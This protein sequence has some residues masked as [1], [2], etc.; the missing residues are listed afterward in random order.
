MR[1]KIKTPGLRPRPRLRDTRASSSL[2]HYSFSDMMSPLPLFVYFDTADMHCPV[3]A[4]CKPPDNKTTGPQSDPR[5]DWDMIRIHKSKRKFKIKSNRPLLW[6]YNIWEKK[7]ATNW[8]T[9]TQKSAWQRY[10]KKRY[11]NKLKSRYPN[12]LILR[13]PNK[14]EAK[15]FLKQSNEKPVAKTTQNH[16]NN[17]PQPG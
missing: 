12:E 11:P 2:N 14:H 1:L 3:H 17:T 13:Y 10:V 7:H 15:M 8:Y 9:K 16:G 6:R 5:S 4:R